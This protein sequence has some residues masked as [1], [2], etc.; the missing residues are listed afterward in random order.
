MLHNSSKLCDRLNGQVTYYIIDETDMKKLLTAVG[1]SVIELRN[2]PLVAI[3]SSSS[4][5]E[6]TTIVALLKEAGIFRTHPDDPKYRINPVIVND[7]SI[8]TEGRANIDVLL[9]ANEDIVASS[10]A[11]KNLILKNILNS[12]LTTALTG[13][14]Y[15]RQKSNYGL[16]DPDNDI[17]SGVN[18]Y[19][20]W[21]MTGFSRPLQLWDRVIIKTGNVLVPTDQAVHFRLNNNN[22]FVIVPIAD[23]PP[24]VQAAQGGD[25][26]AIYALQGNNKPSPN[27]QYTPDV[28]SFTS[29]VRIVGFAMFELIDLKDAQNNKIGTTQPG[30]VRGKF[31]KYVIDP[32]EVAGMDPHGN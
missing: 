15:V 3:C 21:F 11:A 1:E 4:I 28:A 5:S 6:S 30:Q 14:D 19:R 22:R 32:R 27:G 24:E 17:D 2:Q 12:S 16:L 8:I 25:I 29:A 9:M 18:N 31:V 13:H 10:T 7:S 23:I 20:D 26:D